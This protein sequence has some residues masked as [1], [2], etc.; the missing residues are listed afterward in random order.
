MAAFFGGYDVPFSSSA[1]MQIE[2]LPAMPSAGPPS[3]SPSASPSPSPSVEPSPSAS[4]GPV[5]SA[6]SAGFTYTTLDG[7]GTTTGNKTPVKVSVVDTSTGSPGC[8]ITAWTWHWGDG[9]PD[10]QGQN[11]P[12]HFYYNPGPASIKTYSLSLVVVNC[13]EAYCEATS[14][15]VLITV[16]K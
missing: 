12:P 11:A 3:P 5:C 10:F 7:H 14:G 4:V 1:T 9:M 6:P 8:P 16:K 13:P 15:T 2:T